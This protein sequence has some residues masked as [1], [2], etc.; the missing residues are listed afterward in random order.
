MDVR[1][2]LGD[3]ILNSGQLIIGLFAGRTNFTHFCAVFSCILQR[4][5]KVSDVISSRFLYVRPIVPDKQVNFCSPQLSSYRKI[6]PEVVGGGIFDGF[7]AIT[8]DWK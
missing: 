2:K 4:Q 6:L 3:S 7:F 1:V 8:S 5:K